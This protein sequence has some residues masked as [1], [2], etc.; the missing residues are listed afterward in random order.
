MRFRGIIFRVLRLEVSAWFSYTIEK[1]V[2][3]VFIRFSSF[4]LYSV[5]KR[6]VETVRGCVSL[7]KK[8]SQ[9]KAVEATLNSKEENSSDICLDFVQEFGLC[10]LFF[11]ASWAIS[12]CKSDLS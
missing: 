4:L 12:C 8:K 9:G 6:D 1:G 7:K 3:V 2:G 11:F 5:H 10:I